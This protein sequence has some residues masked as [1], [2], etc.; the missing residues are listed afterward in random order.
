MGNEINGVNPRIG[1]PVFNGKEKEESGWG[2]PHL[3]AGAVGGG[4][5]GYLMSKPISAEKIAG[6]TADEFTKTIGE[7]VPAEYRETVDEIKTALTNKKEFLKSNTDMATEA[8][9][10]EGKNSITVE[11]LLQK[12]GK[13]KEELTAATKT[14]QEKANELSEKLSKAATGSPEFE[15]LTF[16][17]CVKNAE[18]KTN[19]MFIE[20][21]EQAKDGNITKEVIEGLY[22]KTGEKTFVEA[23]GTSVK[24]IESILPKDFW[25]KTGIGAA[26]GLGLGAVLVYLF[27]GKKETAPERAHEA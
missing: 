16:N 11:E 25:K 26:I 17:H 21:I 8:I 7:N 19:K 4:A 24:K 14:L 12:I 2:V 15:S 6:L 9:F 5:T 1:H 18:L 3:L 23:L 20:A 27:G 10:Q 22:S 13:T